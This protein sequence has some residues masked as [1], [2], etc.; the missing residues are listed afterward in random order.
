[1]NATLRPTFRTSPARMCPQGTAFAL[2]YL[3]D[4]W[5]NTPHSVLLAIAIPRNHILA[6]EV[7]NISLVL[8]LLKP[9]QKKDKG[10]PK[11]LHVA[12]K[13]D[14][15]GRRE[16][17]KEKQKLIGGPIGVAIGRDQADQSRYQ[18]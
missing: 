6:G 11:P 2:L 12:I 10:D 8:Q 15:D 3:A 18:S 1:M 5:F 9:G 7:R 16:E 13:A 14:Q 17:E 4:V